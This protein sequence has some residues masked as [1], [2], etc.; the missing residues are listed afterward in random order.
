VEAVELSGTV[1]AAREGSA[2]VELESSVDAAM[3]VAWR[4][5]MRRVFD[6]EEENKKR[7]REV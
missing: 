1:P 7:Q 2:G 6:I 5:A 4:V 3:E